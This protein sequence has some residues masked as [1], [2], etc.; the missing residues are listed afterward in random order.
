MRSILTDN[1]KVCYLCGSTKDVDLHHCIHGK[2][3]R[4]ISTQYHLVVGLCYNC[5]RGP[6]G[7]HNKQNGQSKD[8]RLKHDA[9]VAWELKR[10]KKKGVSA[11]VA[12]DEW[13][14]VFKEDFIQ[15]Y[16]DLQKG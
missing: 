7:V 16:N 8:L 5:H 4:K 11:Q 2:E 3:W 12:R 13:L 14:S 9:Q 15:Q 6:E 10:V 1:L